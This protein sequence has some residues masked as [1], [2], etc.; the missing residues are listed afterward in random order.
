[1]RAAMG[2][3]T[4]LPANCCVNFEAAGVALGCLS[5]A[6]GMGTAAL[7]GEIAMALHCGHL[8]GIQT[9]R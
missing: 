5:T 1:M 6:G 4:A 7:P 3:R 8:E 9:A 2:T